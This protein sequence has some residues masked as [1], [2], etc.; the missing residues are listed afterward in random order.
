MPDCNKFRSMLQDWDHWVTNYHY[1]DVTMRA[2]A[3]QITGVSIVYSNVCPGADQRKHQS[4]TSLAFVRGIHRW[5]LN[6]PHKGRVTRKMFPCDIVTM[7]TLE[8][9]PAWPTSV[10]VNNAT[11]EVNVFPVGTTLDVQSLTHT[12]AR[13]LCLNPVIDIRDM[14]RETLSSSCII[15]YCIQ[16]TDYKI[17]L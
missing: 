9:G 11:A 15:W 3:S 16:H 12:R 1:N 5:P 14:L 17:E 8:V 7:T 2:M 6:S 10:L 13:F 4:S